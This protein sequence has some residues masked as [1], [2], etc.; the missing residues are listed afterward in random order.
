MTKEKL[1]ELLK[2]DLTNEYQ[3]MIYYLSAS[4]RVQ[5]LHREEISEFLLKEAQDEMSH[6]DEFSRLI[7]DLGG[8][9]EFEPLHYPSPSSNPDEIL[10]HAMVMENEVV[11]RYVGRIEDAVSLG[12]VDGKYIEIFLEEQIMD[13]RK[14]A[15]NLKEMLLGAKSE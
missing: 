3:H 1:V 6:V 4:F 9:P 12:G 14:T 8:E 11:A 2:A 15:A 13:S 5:G 10:K 7:I